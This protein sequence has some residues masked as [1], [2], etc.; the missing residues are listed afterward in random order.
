MGEKCVLC[1]YHRCT[2]SLTF[3]HLDPSKKDFSIN[4]GHAHSWSSIVVE[5]RKCVLLCHNC[6]NEVHDGMS[7]VP[8]DAIRFDEVYATYELDG[9]NIG[10]GRKKKTEIQ[11]GTHSSYKY[12]KCR[13]ELCRKKNREYTRDWK[14]NKKLGQVA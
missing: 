14:R 5:L 7:V 2:R 13:C 1:A 4:C 12:H 10:S 8:E 6:H 11:H 9:S 3:H